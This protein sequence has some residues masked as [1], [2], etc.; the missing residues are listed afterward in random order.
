MND[1][2]CPICN[3]QSHFRLKKENVDYF[4][5]TNCKTIFCDALDNDNMVGG[6]AEIERN[7]QQNYLRI[8]RVKMLCAGEKINEMNVLDFG[9]GNGMLIEDLKK[10]GFNCDG[11]DAYNEKYSKLPEKN[12][13]H[14]ITAIEVCEHFSAPYVEYDVMYRSLLPN[15]VL[16]IETSFVDVAQQEGIEMEDFFYINP[17]AGHS[18]IHSHHGLDLLLALKKFKP[19]QH[20]NR[21]VRVFIKK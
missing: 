7:E 20:F 15:G 13:Y 21:H 17:L 11:Y 3:N 18:T 9:C 10:T 4:Q 12:K 1:K 14:V 8:E 2:I 19:S 6:G 5:C 16:M